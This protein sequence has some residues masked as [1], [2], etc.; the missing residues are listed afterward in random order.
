MR[1]TDRRAIGMDLKDVE[2]GGPLAC[3]FAGRLVTAFGK[4]GARFQTG[5][6]RA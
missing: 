5:G 6:S 3:P 4:S 2:Y 1:Q